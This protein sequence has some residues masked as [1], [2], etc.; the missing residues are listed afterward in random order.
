[1]DNIISMQTPICEVC[2]KSEILCN[3]CQDKLDKGYSVIYGES[4]RNMTLRGLKD[5][6]AAIN[7]QITSKEVVTVVGGPNAS[8]DP[9]GILEMGVNY[10][11]LGEGEVTLPELVKQIA[12]NEN[13]EICNCRPFFSCCCFRK[14]S[15]SR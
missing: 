9:R 10:V 8:G 1:M 3:G 7:R 15:Y 11:V 5:R 14:C 4:S 2:L 13:K 6:L 12:K